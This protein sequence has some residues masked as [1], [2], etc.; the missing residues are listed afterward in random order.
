MANGPKCQVMYIPSHS[1][2]GDVEYVGGVACV[3]KGS[4]QLHQ[5]EDVRRGLCDHSKA[6][7]S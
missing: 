1:Y 6:L 4:E 5:C 2:E 7:S 3:I